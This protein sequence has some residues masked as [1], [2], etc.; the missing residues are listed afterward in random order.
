MRRAVLVAAA[1]LMTAGVVSLAAQAGTAQAGTPQAEPSRPRA[2]RPNMQAM[3][4][5]LGVRCVYCH[6]PGRH[7]EEDLDFKSEANPKKR[8]ARL[9]LAMTADINA[10]VP[11]AV[12]K[13][14]GEVTTVTCVT[15]HRGVADPR[16]LAEILTRTLE[17]QGPDAVV[18]QYR[19]LR[20]RYFG[21]DAYDFSDRTLI[22]VVEPILE[23][24]PAVA[25]TLLRLNL[26]FNPRSADSYVMMARAETRRL[27]DRAAIG[28]L[29]QAL[30]IDPSHGLAQGYLAQLK[31]FTRPRP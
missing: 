20:A 30:A 23:R 24:G 25:L 11:A 7:G 16:P 8:V 13:A 31:Q 14:S 27:D 22:R 1:A 5:A 19:D 10:A 29:E 18:A 12:L 21:R 4:E 17:E 2:P 9:M 6:V 28:L 26:E 15:C 3:N